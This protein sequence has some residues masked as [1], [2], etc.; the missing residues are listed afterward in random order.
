MSH[1][2]ELV[3]MVSMVG[4][5]CIVTFH[6]VTLYMNIAMSITAVHC[7]ILAGH[8]LYYPMLAKVDCTYIHADLATWVY[9]CAVHHD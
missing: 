1:L 7:H 5:E 4:K 2:Q 9:V 6:H 8:P 3:L